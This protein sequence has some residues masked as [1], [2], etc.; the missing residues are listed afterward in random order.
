MFKNS[1]KIA[2]RNIKKHTGFSLIN[3]A[4][5]AIGMAC[6][7]LIMLW[8]KDELSYD[9]FYKNS[10]RICRVARVWF[11]NHGK[12]INMA[13][14]TSAPAIGYLLK[15]DYPQQIEELV[16]VLGNLSFRVIEINGEKF[17]EKRLFHAEENFFQ[18]FTSPFLAGN[19]ETA[20]NGPGNVVITESTASSSC[21]PCWLLLLPVSD[22][23]G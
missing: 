12:S 16:R 10:D 5:L 7:I 15:N 21:L 8:V 17:K 20:L 13:S 23:W 22:F 11:E 19:P 1:L 2:L 14:S 3:I 6:T 18:I 9:K 4:G